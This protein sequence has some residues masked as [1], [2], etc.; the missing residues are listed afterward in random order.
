[1]TRQL[2]PPEIHQ[3]KRQ[4]VQDVRAGNLVV[5]LDP[6]EQRRTPVEQNDVA[7]MEI[8]VTLTHEAGLATS[9]E[10]LRT[11]IKLARGII[12]HTRRCRRLQ[13]GSPELRKPGSVPFDDPGHPSFAA[14]ISA[15]FGSHME[16]RDCRCQW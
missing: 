9:F 12:R 3:E 11:P 13:T 5:E 16:C 15:L 4:I 7:Q 10:Y 1:M 14:M 2:S 6:V 8:T